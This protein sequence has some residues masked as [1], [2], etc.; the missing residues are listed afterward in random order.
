MRARSCARSPTE[1]D[2]SERPIEY[3]SRSLTKTKK[4]KKNAKIEREAL[5]LYWGVRKFPLYLEKRS[6]VPVTDR[7]TLKYIMDLGRAVPVTA[8][9]RL[10]RR[11]LLL[12]AFLSQIEHRS[13]LKHSNCDGLSRLPLQTAEVE[14]PDELKLL[15]A[16]ITD[17]LPVQ[18]KDIRTATRTDSLLARVAAF[19]QDGWNGTNQEMEQKPYFNRRDELTLPQ[20]IIMWGTRVIIPHMLRTQILKTLHERHTGAAKMKGLGRSFVWWPDID[21]DMKHLARDCK[22]CQETASN[23]RRAPIHRWEYPS[24]PWQ[25]LHVDLLEWEFHNSSCQTTVPNLSPKLSGGL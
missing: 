2:G 1:P 5:A 10:Q 6:F 7:K 25:R 19:V 17:T 9:A 11:C 12:D 20:G 24:S 15:H 13:T 22:G 3:A 18:A 23:P 14:E 16:G 21:K 8:A 4:K